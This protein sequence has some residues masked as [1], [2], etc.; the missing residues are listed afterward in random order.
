MLPRS[1]AYRFKTFR[2]V[3][4]GS[5][6]RGLFYLKQR[7]GTHHHSDLSS[8]YVFNHISLV[9]AADG[10]KHYFPCVRQHT[11][12]IVYRLGLGGRQLIYFTF[13]IIYI[14]I[15]LHNSQLVKKNDNIFVK[16]L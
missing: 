11:N 16:F 1:E 2:Y 13:L 9:L 12:R 3:I 10:F 8:E 6:H 7:E 14:I 5:R 15:I 4:K